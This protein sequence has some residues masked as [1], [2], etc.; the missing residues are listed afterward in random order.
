MRNYTDKPKTLDKTLDTII[1]D[2]SRWSYIAYMKRFE[3]YI[4]SKKNLQ[5]NVMIIIITIGS[6]KFAAEFILN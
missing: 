1:Y 2:T 6:K 3:H 5:K 4:N